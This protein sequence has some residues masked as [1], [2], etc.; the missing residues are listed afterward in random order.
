MKRCSW[1]LLCLFT[2]SPAF[3]AGEAPAADQIVVRMEACRAT[4]PGVPKSILEAVLGSTEALAHRGVVEVGGKKYT[5]YLPRAKSYSVKN[6]ARKENTFENTSTRLSIDQTGSGK[7]T[8][9]DEWPANLPVRLGDRMFDVVAI[10]ADGSR[11]VLKPSR[12][13]L[14]GVVVGRACPPFAFKT[15][16]GKEVSRESL[17]GKAFLLDIWSIT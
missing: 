5:L 6:T 17:A 11:V 13:P 7:L 9:S 3:P 14:S 15:A 2:P 8:E 10:A 16:E 1:L 4:R 12:A